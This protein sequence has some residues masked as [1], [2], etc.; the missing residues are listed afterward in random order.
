MGKDAD[1]VILD[2]HPF[3][4]NT[5]VEQTF[6]NGKLLYEKSKSPYFSHIIRYDDA[7]SGRLPE[8]RDSNEA[9]ADVAQLYH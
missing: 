3:H 1:I 5:F 7:I 6:V 2:G 4:Y 8:P 9:E